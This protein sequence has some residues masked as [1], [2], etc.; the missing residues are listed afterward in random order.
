MKQ[1]Y[2][3]NNMSYKEC[4]KSDDSRSFA[5]LGIAFFWL[6]CFTWAP[7]AFAQYGDG[8]SMVPIYRDARTYIDYIEDDLDK[9][10]VRIEFD[11]LR[12]TKTTERTL[13]PGWEYGIFAFG[14]YTM[15]DIDIKVYKKVFGTWTLIKSDTEDDRSA[16]V[17]ISPTATEDYRIEISC[18]RFKGNYSVGH[19]GLIIFHE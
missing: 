16:M 19:Y 1:M 15:A 9:E 10:I 5:K 12:T 3:K 11:I 17:T 4:K 6:L 2:K 14:D 8:T 13:S 7:Q 18:Y